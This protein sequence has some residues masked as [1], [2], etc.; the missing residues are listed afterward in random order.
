MNPN[1]ISDFLKSHRE[2]NG[3]TQEKMAEHIGV[4]YRTYQRIESNQSSLTA[5][6]LLRILQKVDNELFVKFL[7]TIKSK[8]TAPTP[9]PYELGELFKT[10][11]MVKLS[12]TP[13]F[14]YKEE[15]ESVTQPDLIAYWE[16]N[17]HTDEKYTSPEFYEVYQIEEGSEYSPE[18][19][20]KHIFPEDLEKIEMGMDH[21][22]RFNIPYT[23]QHRVKKDKDS[24]YIV[25][26]S[27]VLVNVEA[28]SIIVGYL[29]AF[30]VS[31][32]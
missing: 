14:G 24:Y 17:P 22:F 25:N 18:D 15:H 8:D 19:I 32:K 21:L 4:S 3:I 13:K 31:K 5:T 11:D 7:N 9:R 6:Q 29:K 26:A 30:L 20:A 10:K 16:W 2:K 1:I 23:N 28:E 12:Q 27:A